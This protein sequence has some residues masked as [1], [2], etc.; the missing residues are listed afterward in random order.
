MGGPRFPKQNRDHLFEVLLALQQAQ[1][2]ASRIDDPKLNA[3]A[4]TAVAQA[5]EAL[6]AAYEATATA[7]TAIGGAL[8]FTPSEAPAD[9]DDDLDE[10]IQ[11]HQ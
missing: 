11:S 8:T 2:A 7:F 10:A 4:R 1:R 3:E 9:R 5:V 6:A